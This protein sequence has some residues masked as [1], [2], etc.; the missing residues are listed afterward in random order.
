MLEKLG[1]QLGICLSKNNYIQED[2]IDAVRYWFEVVINEYILLLINIW[3]GFILDKGIETIVYLSVFV[4]LRKNIRGYHCKTMLNC[5]IVSFLLYFIALFLSNKIY[6]YFWI[7]LIWSNTYI[8]SQYKKSKNARE[9]LSLLFITCIIVLIFCNIGV[10]TIVNI[11]VISM[12]QVVAFKKKE[13]N[14]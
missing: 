4:F 3:I 11:M 9:I 12:V 14:E 13:N 5:N 1:I 10:T 8:L 6:N 7:L 2:D